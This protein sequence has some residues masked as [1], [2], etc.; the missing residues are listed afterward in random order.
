MA[1]ALGA[2]ETVNVGD[3]AGGANIFRNYIEGSA[4]DLIFGEEYEL[5]CAK[6]GVATGALR[7]TASTAPEVNAQSHRAPENADMK[8]S[9][10][11]RVSRL[12]SLPRF[13]PVAREVPWVKSGLLSILTGST[14]TVSQGAINI[15]S[16]DPEHT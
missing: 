4:G 11:A 16:T 8:I 7:V 5:T 9:A 10:R 6:G 13:L 2:S 1:A 3:I 15:V 14:S 12:L